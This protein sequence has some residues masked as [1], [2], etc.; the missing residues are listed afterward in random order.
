MTATCVSAIKGTLFRL[1]KLD[2]CGVPVTGASG[3]V[4]TSAGFIA[5]KPSPQ[6]EEGTEFIQKLANGAL[7]VNQKDAP[8]LKR[9]ALDVSVCTMDPDMIVM[10]TGSRL[11]TN[12]ATGTGVFFNDAINLARVSVEVWQQ[13]AGRASCIN[14]LQQYI[15]WAF[16]N[17]GH[18]MVGD[19]SIENGV[20]NFDLKMETDE[21]YPSWGSLPT[22][23]PPTGYLNSQTF[24]VGDHY[25]YNVTTTAP[26][27]AG[28]G[29]VTLV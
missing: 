13:V 14:G 17:T 25:A 22:A 6:Y 19:W 23:T 10:V 11:I 7:C 27:V 2:Q 15:Y 1:I 3:A 21:A 12:G 5:I 28:C 9:V 8:T 16:A 29:A 18:G 24:Q 20:L 26:P 4:V